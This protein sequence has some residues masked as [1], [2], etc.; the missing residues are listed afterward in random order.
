MQ[1]EWLV[2]PRW[3]EQPSLATSTV[4]HP[5]GRSFGSQRIHSAKVY[6]RVETA[7]EQTMGAS[8]PIQHF[9]ELCSVL[10]RSNLLMET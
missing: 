9:G 8:W 10:G 6:S 3:R 5:S 2:L 1:G 7:N 4:L